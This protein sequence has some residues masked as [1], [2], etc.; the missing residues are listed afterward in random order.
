MRRIAPS[1]LTNSCDGYGLV[2][3]E[4]GMVRGLGDSG[5]AG[6]EGAWLNVIF[7]LL[8]IPTP[9]D[10]SSATYNFHA[11]ALLVMYRYQLIIYLWLTFH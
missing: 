7:Q 9:P 10:V 3:P 1:S 2:T 11:P 8:S 5:I 6:G 4:I